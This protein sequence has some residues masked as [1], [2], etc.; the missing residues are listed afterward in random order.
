MA[1]TEE[2]PGK[3]ETCCRGVEQAAAEE[4]KEEGRPSMGVTLIGAREKKEETGSE[5]GGLD[6]KMD[7]ASQVKNVQGMTTY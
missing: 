5:N 1:R 7:D 2:T 4:T 3:S 6:A